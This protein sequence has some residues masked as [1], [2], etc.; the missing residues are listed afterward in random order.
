MIRRFIISILFALSTTSA[1]AQISVGEYV[2]SVVEYS[3]DIIS[4]EAKVEGAGAE[5]RVAR[6]SVLPS[7]SLSSD[8][9]FGF[10]DDVHLWTMQADILQPI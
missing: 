7:M 9:N 1:M 8:A 5:Y 6:R 4:A 3:H 2:A 10:D